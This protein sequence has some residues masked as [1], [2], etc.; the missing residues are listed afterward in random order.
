MKILHILRSEPS[1][2]VKGFIEA[3]AEKNESEQFILY[4]NE[5]DYSKLTENI[6]AA[7]YVI[8]WW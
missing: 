1:G 6:F 8:S 2:M 7:D 5:V 4:K 3:F